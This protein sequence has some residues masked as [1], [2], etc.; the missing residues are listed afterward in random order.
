M[1][2]HKVQYEHE[3]VLDLT[4]KKICYDRVYSKLNNVRIKS[5]YYT[6][7]GIKVGK[8]VVFVSPA[9]SDKFKTNNVSIK[10]LALND[11]LKI[12]IQENF[13]GKLKSIRSNLL[14]D[15]PWFHSYL[16]S[17]FSLKDLTNVIIFFER[18]ES[19]SSFS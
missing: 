11:N 7:S 1:S 15:E 12:D 19:L 10:Y 18:L 5:S 8:Y 3:V 13:G 2:A 14:Q 4:D 16:S 9:K 17:S 6:K